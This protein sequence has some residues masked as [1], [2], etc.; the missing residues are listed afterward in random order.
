M[1][2]IIADK[3]ELIKICKQQHIKPL[4]IGEDVELVTKENTQS[5]ALITIATT[6]KRTVLESNIDAVTNIEDSKKNDFMH[7]KAAG[8]DQVTA[9]ILAKRNNAL[10]INLQAYFKAEDKTTH[11]GRVLQNIRI[12]DKKGAPIIFA[13]FAHKTEQQPTIHDL[14]AFWNAMGVKEEITKK[15]QTHLQELIKRG[16]K[17]ASKN[18]VAEGITTSQE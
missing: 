8:L 9:K 3:K 14:H 13:S 15:S 6:A 1:Y 11:I 5:N 4:I 2:D 17:R 7:H 18:Y 16:E 10:I 12:A